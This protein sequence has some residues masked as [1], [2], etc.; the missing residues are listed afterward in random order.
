MDITVDPED[1][2]VEYIVEDLLPAGVVHAGVGRYSQASRSCSLSTSLRRWRWACRGWVTRRSVARCSWSC[3]KAHGTPTC[4]GC[5]HGA[6]L[7]VS[8]GVELDEWLTPSFP[9]HLHLVSPPEVEVEHDEYGQE[10]K[11]VVN[12]NERSESLTSA[13]T[14]DPRRAVRP[15]GGRQ[16]QMGHARSI[17][18]CRTATWATPSV[19]CR[20]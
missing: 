16:L 13:A 14:C 9:D 4:N 1:V 19:P 20:R 12:T 18:R 15:R 5:M 6:S 2:P 11:R 7:T 10:H 3:S 17:E 8:T